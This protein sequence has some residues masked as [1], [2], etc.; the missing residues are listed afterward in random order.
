VISRIVGGKRVHIHVRCCHVRSPRYLEAI[1]R[2]P[3]DL[4]RSAG[5]LMPD[6]AAAAA[7][8]PAVLGVL[9]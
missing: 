8:L 2:R 4:V 3:G 1:E 9:V 7:A 5:V 6:A